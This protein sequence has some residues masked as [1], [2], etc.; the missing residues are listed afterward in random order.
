MED[1]F[2]VAYQQ[3]EDEL[4][5]E[6]AFFGIYDGHGGK[7]AALFAKVSLSDNS[8]QREAIFF[9]FKGHKLQQKILSP[10]VGSILI[11]G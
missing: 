3:T 10:I 1:V 6:Y 11:A 5:L 9:L 7:E 8:V 4:D 2:S